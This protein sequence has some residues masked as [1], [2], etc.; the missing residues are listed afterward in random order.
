MTTGLYSRCMGEN[1]TVI[2]MAK[3]PDEFEHIR[4]LVML[5]VVSGGRSSSDGRRICI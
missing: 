2:A 5:M 4:A 1:S 3:W